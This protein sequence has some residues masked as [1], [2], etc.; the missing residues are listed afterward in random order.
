M[1]TLPESTFPLSGY[2]FSITKEQPRE[3]GIRTILN[4]AR[5]NLQGE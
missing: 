5:V 2:Y 4:M 1:T 3:Y